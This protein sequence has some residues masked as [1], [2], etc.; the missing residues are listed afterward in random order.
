MTRLALANAI[1]LKADWKYPF[2]KAFTADRPF[3][4]VAGTS[5][6]VPTMRGDVVMPTRRGTGW[7]AASLPYAGDK[8]A[9]LL[10]LPD[11]GQEQ[12]L[13]RLVCS[14]AL[15]DLLKG[16]DHTRPP[17]SAPRAGEGNAEV[18]LPK[19]RIASTHDLARP[20]RARGAELAFSDRADF[21]ALTRTERLALQFATQKA[22]IVVDELGTEAAAVT[23]I[24]AMAASGRVPPPELRFDRPF[25]AV[26]YDT[27]TATPLF[28]TYVADPSKR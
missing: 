17:E 21:S 23:A 1:Y 6:P 15:S 2:D 28:L 24:G 10:V 12:Q 13:R 22:T 8:L 16:W 3:T 14:P 5:A 9:M 18:V 20:L 7:H 4:T 27:P 25:Y 26:V 19:F 11:L